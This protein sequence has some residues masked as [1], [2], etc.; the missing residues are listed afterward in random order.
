MPATR[1]R[2]DG[3]RP[4]R[5]ALALLLAAEGGPLG[6]VRRALLV[7]ALGACVIAALAVAGVPD[8][9]AGLRLAGVAAVAVLALVW[10]RAARR[11]A[12]SPWDEPIELLALFAVGLAAGPA[13]SLVVFYAGL[14]LRSLYGSRLRAA[15]GLVVY[16]AAYV[17]A[18]S[19]AGGG[20][21]REGVRAV[22]PCAGGRSSCRRWRSGVR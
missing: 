12:L 16:A 6:R 21:V 8:R 20:G 13:P 19:A 14:Y 18:V 5:G 10:I 9:T 11:G 15:A 17:G 2:A 22:A 7:V 4:A 3:T 1:D